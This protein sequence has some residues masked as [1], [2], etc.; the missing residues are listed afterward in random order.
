MSFQT[1][2]CGVAPQVVP[3]RIV[4]YLEEGQRLGIVCSVSKGSLPIGFQWRK[5]NALVISNE[6]LKIL[7]HEDYQESLQILGLS[8]QHIGNYTCSARNAFGSDQM[9]VEVIFNFKPRWTIEN[10][11]QVIDAV[12]GATVS[13][14]CEALGH[15]KPTVKVTKGQRIT[16]IPFQKY[17]V[18]T[19]DIKCT[20][21]LG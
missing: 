2:R 3:F 12:V 16:T 7:H 18:K 9:S 10:I 15:P 17:F 13:I 11:S 4:E 1:V 14:A 5:D 20:F 6:Y 19:F 8:T 21:L